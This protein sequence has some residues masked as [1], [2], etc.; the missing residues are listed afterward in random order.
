[1][2]ALSQSLAR[3]GGNLTGITN[4]AEG[5]LAKRLQILHELVPAATTVAML[6]NPDNTSRWETQ[7]PA[8]ARILGLNLL[9]VDARNEND[10]ATAFASIAAQR[11]GAL[12]GKGRRIL[13]QAGEPVR[14]ARRALWDSRATSFVCLRQPAA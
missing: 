2:L 11:A 7:G 1:M 5:L 13:Y 6:T 3:P 10:I 14:R 9:V 12:F 8:A 4:L